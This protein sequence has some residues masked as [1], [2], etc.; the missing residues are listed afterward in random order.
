MQ[1]VAASCLALRIPTAYK[2]FIAVN[3]IFG[4]WFGCMYIMSTHRSII[5]REGVLSRRSNSI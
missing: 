1:H 2:N 4:V 3:R 5:E